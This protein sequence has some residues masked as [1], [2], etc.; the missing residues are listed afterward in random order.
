[1]FYFTIYTST[2]LKNDR[3]QRISSKSI[4][5]DTSVCSLIQLAHDSDVISTD[6]VQTE[7]HLSS[8]GSCRKH[9]LVRL[10]HHQVDALVEALQGADEVAS[11]GRDYW[12]RTVH[13]WFQAGSHFEWWICAIAFWQMIRKQT[14]V[15]CRAKHNLKSFGVER[16]RKIEHVCFILRMFSNRYLRGECVWNSSIGAR[17][18]QIWEFWTNENKLGICVRNFEK[19][20]LY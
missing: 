2:Y 16:I 14:S 5:I 6:E 19:I 4:E 7:H 20:I 18:G 13:E 15:E 9:P 1:M 3:R 10:L 8:R 12:N 11:V 17:D